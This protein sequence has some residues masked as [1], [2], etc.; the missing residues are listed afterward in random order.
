[1]PDRSFFGSSTG[2][3]TTDRSDTGFEHQTTRKNVK[4]KPNQQIE[5]LYGIHPVFEALQAGR[6]TFHQI[7]LVQDAQNNRLKP[8]TDLAGKQR[9]SIQWLSR[10]ALAVKCGTDLHQGVAAAVTP[11]P[12]CDLS[13]IITAPA[14]DSEKGRFILMIDSV[15]DP[16]N[17]GALVRTA[18]CAGADGIII[19]KDRAASPT[20][21]ASKASAGAIE[22]AGI[23]QVTNLVNTIQILQKQ[24]IWVFGTAAD[25]KTSLF[26]T[27][28]A[29]P[30][31]VVIGSEEKG[32]RPLVQ[33]NCDFL[34]SIPQYGPVSSLNASAAGAVVMYEIL[35]RRSMLC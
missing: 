14:G 18:L 22:H 4:P 13:E 34:V 3:P 17:L 31:A 16:Q 23:C 10:A 5:I 11:Y 21:A 33:K 30:T 20:P 27:K 24:G 9:V 25:A 12:F 32:I 28:I 29:F 2:I 1:M 26:S 19:P 8:I 6:R 15:E 7:Y 35:R